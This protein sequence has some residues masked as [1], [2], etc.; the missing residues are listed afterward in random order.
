[1]GS[2][3]SY[4]RETKWTKFADERGFLVVLPSGSNITDGKC[5]DVGTKASLSSG[6]EAGGDTLAIVNMVRYA[7]TKYNADPKKVFV[8]GSSSGAMMTMTIAAVYPDI[9]AGGAAYSGLPSGCLAGSPGFGPFTA[10]QTCAKGNKILSPT[11][12][13][14]RARSY[15]PSFKG[16]YS[17]CRSG[18]EQ[19]ILLLNTPIWLRV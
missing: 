2:G 5:W 12:W 13:G 10:D 1:M 7:I 16:E 14:T 15:A 3:P 9:F 6:P 19:L 18:M 4:T 8:T 11:E 17:V